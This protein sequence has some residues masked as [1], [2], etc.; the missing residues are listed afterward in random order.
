[1]EG[2]PINNMWTSITQEEFDEFRVSPTFIA[3]R[4]P[5]S[6]SAPS[7]NRLSTGTTSNNSN[8]SPADIFRRGI[9]RDP[10]LFPILKDEKFNDR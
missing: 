1:M 10:T 3:T 4:T 5:S 9:K 2:N 7:T 8:N 6:I